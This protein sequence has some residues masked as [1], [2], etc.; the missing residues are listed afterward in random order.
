MLFLLRCARLA[1]AVLLCVCVPAV[2]GAAPEE[3]PNFVLILADDLGYS[4]LGCYGGEIRTPHLDRLASRGLRFTQFYNAA[5]CCP[6]RASLLTGLHPHQAGVGHMTYDAG[7]PGYQGDLRHGAATIAEALGAAGYRTM[8]A[9]KWHV[10]QNTSPDGDR[11]N[12]PLQTGVRRILR[13]VARPRKLLGSGWVDV[14]KP[15][16][17]RR[18]R[19]LLHGGYHGRC[20][21]I[22]PE[23]E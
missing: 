18:R 12:W 20:S 9:G 2:F 8:M 15:A 7:Q 23:R 13:Y 1:Q 14:G 6:T 11:S 21:R 22:T 10:A 17:C 4:D 3:R 19:F 16:H 5:R